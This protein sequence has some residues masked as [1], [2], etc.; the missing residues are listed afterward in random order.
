MATGDFTVFEEFADQIGEEGHKL[1][2]DTLKL[3]LV[4]DTLTPTAADATP[5]WADYSAN[6]V[7]PAGGYT[8]DGITLS[9]VTWTEAAGVATLDDTGNISLAQNASGFTDARWGIL[10]NDTNAGKMAIGFLDLGAA[11]SEVAGPVAI[12]WGASGIL[13]ITVS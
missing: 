8:A 2:T 9:G 6:D 1:D 13:T 10:Y 3:G 5:T 4:D 12:N 11:V 7:S